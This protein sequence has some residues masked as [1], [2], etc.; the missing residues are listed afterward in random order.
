MKDFI[1]TVT[2]ETLQK[3]LCVAI[4]GRGA[5]GRFKDVLRDYEVERQNWFDFSGNRELTRVAE[6][7]ES[8]GLTPELKEVPINWLSLSSSFI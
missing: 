8:N 2:N 6:W 1:D 7:L 3:L 5:F 4:D